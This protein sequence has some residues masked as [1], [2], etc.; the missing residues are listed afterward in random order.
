MATAVSKPSVMQSPFFKALPFLPATHQ[1]S[2]FP[3]LGQPLPPK[4]HRNYSDQPILSCFPS[5]ALSFFFF[6]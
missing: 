5:P 6:F 1:T 2:M 4:A 3:G